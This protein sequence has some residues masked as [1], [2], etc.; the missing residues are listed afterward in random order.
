MAALQGSSRSG[1]HI[2]QDLGA[3]SI[4]AAKN[5]L[6]LHL[7]GLERRAFCRCRHKSV[8]R[9]CSGRR[10]GGRRCRCSGRRCSGCRRDRSRRGRSRCGSSR[11]DKSR[12]DRRCDRCVS[13]RRCDRCGKSRCGSWRRNSKYISSR[14]SRR[15]RRHLCLCTGRCVGLG[16]RH[17]H[18][19]LCRL[20]LY[21]TLQFLL[22]AR[23]IEQ[24]CRNGRVKHSRR[25][26]PGGPLVAHT[27]L[28]LL[29]RKETGECLLQA[30]TNTRSAGQTREDEVSVR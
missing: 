6:N 12:R 23:N 28:Q 27:L 14:R 10:C 24:V 29:R 19:R 16:S 30:A 15:C 26:P 18:Y 11:R 20:R 13:S 22:E 21:S 1:N 2:K 9:R 3:H 25:I 4:E 7:G 8:W 17:V 5:A